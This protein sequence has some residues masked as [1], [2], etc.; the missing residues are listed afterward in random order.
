MARSGKLA[1]LA[2]VV[3]LAACLA[4]PSGAAAWSSGACP[5]SAGVTVVVDFGAF[6]GGAITRCVPDLPGS[7]LA[8][9]SGAGFAVTP[10][11]TQPAFV[12]RIDGLPD[13]SSESCTTIP[14]A[15]A[16]WSYWTADRG[17]AWRY[18]PVGAAASRPA[19]A[20]VEGWTF[21]T[22][23]APTPPSVLPPPLTPP[24]PQPTPRAT[25]EP[26]AR[27]APAATPRPTTVVVATISPTPSATVEPS[28]SPSPSEPPSVA[29]APS[30]SA[31]PEAGAPAPAAA[32]P[33]AEPGPLGTMLGI[34][35]IA[36]VGGAAVLASRRFERADG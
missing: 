11:T 19:A 35:A 1:S 16:S 30:E 29:V 34:G 4:V 10:V 24:T 9:L 18:S 31:S 13:A 27:P 20:T 7:G 8:A 28:P 21:M 15:T 3:A 36:I 6:G 5:T 32:P 14:A 33:P 25:P 23:G 2:A 17:G 26:T 12:C 22:G